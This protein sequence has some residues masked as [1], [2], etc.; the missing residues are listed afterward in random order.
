MQISNNSAQ[1]YLNVLVAYWSYDSVLQEGWLSS[2][3]LRHNKPHSN[4][5]YNS[6]G[7]TQSSL[8]QV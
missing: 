3:Q 7:S 2:N 8:H 1:V 5:D 6:E 4:L